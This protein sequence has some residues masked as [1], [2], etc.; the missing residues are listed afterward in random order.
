[1]SFYLMRGKYSQDAMNALVK[2]PEDRLITTTKLL[3]GVG[4]RLHYFFFCLCEFDFVLLYELPDN[5]SAAA[6]SMVMTSAGSVASTETT[7]LLTM[8]QAISAMQKAG[9]ATGV[10]QPPGRGIGQNRTKKK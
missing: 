9:E 4:G 8:E 10:Y 3:Q 5:E 6:L 2:R 7:V 1:M